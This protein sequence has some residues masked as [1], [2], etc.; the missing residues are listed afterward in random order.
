MELQVTKNQ[1]KP[2]VILYRRDDSTTTW[3]H[4]DDFFVMHDLSHF[5]IEKTLG[6]T[7][8]FMGMLNRGMD[9]K[10]FESREKRLQLTIAP[11]AVFAENMANLFLMEIVQG[12]LEDFNQTL[13][14]SFKS[15]G[16]EL[17][18]PVLL[19]HE[20]HSIRDYLRKLIDDWKN[21]EMGK[22]LILSF[23]FLTK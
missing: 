3:M 8:A 23:L 19:D 1:G 9:I 13:G 15:M 2:H 21:L 5:A 11:E 16:K 14:Q 20:I 4:A 18:P 6:Y 10:E 22:T 17:N 12:N 7:E